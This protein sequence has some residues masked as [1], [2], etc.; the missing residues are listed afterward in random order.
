MYEYYADPANVHI[1]RDSGTGDMGS[2]SEPVPANEKARFQIVGRDWV[3]RFLRIHFTGTA[4]SVADLG[5]NI[6]SVAGPDHDTRLFTLRDRGTSDIGDVN[7]RIPL[8]EL[9]EWTFGAGDVLV[10]T[11][12]NPDSGNISWG[13]TVGL[14]PVKPNA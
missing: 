3:L 7:F 8:H 14:M 1:F 6:D 4:D 2:L 13:A 9:G 11:W 5:I 10:P 12:T